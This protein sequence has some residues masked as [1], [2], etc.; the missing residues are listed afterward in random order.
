[1]SVYLPAEDVAVEEFL[2]TG[3]LGAAPAFDATRNVPV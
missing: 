2:A 1:M 3:A